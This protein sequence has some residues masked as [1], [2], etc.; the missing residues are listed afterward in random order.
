LIGHELPATQFGENKP[1]LATN[2]SANMRAAMEA[3]GPRISELTQ[4]QIMR[5]V[6][7]GLNEAFIVNDTDRKQFIDENPECAE[8]IKPLLKGDD[9]R[10]FELHPR[11][12]YLL[13]TDHGVN[14]KRYPA[15]E[16]HLKSYRHKLE[17]R[18]TQ[19]EWYELQQPQA[20]YTRN[21]HKHKFYIQSSVSIHD[22]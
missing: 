7:T 18:A 3:S 14:I 2:S 20:A 15:I 17:N 11:G 10:R 22:S 19:Q 5:G 12:L 21:F 9:V 4:C 1:R 6:V 16:K 8:I 13:Y